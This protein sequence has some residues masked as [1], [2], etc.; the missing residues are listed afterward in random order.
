MHGGVED[1]TQ[2]AFASVTLRRDSIYVPDKE[3]EGGVGD[4]LYTR[5]QG[6]DLYQF[7]GQFRLG[8]SN[9]NWFRKTSA[10]V[11]IPSRSE[12]ICCC[13]VGSVATRG[14]DF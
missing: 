12:L 7:R 3:S 1:E 11:E 13:K 2:L 5:S 14:E 4:L 8:L 10:S 9:W 6:G